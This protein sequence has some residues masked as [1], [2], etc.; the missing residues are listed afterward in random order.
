MLSVVLITL[1]EEVNLR[2]T[3][4]PLTQVSEN[5]VVVD[6]MSSDATLEVCREHGAE[7]TQRPWEGYSKAKNFGASLAK[8]DW[9][10]SID[11]DEVLSDELIATLRE[12]H[13]TLGKAYALDRIT[14]YAGKWIK[15]SGWYPDWKVRLYHRDRAE[16]V[17]D[18]V[19]EELRLLP[20]TEVVR[21]PGK[22]YH[23]SYT[24]SEDHLNRIERYANLSAKKMKASGRKWKRSQA[25]LSPFAR[26]LRTYFLK[27]GVLDGSEGWKIS[28]RNSYM[29]RLKYQR[30][31]K[32]WEEEE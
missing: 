1:N 16:W 25:L 29:V 14:N 23:Y 2:R 10:L 15:H 17:G 11:A 30:L 32:L 7:V 13:P 5:I 4:P 9:I 21:L 27:L 24:S 8:H 22:L 18:F 20:N 19:H 26:F 31:R 12:L 3:L 28:R 6:A